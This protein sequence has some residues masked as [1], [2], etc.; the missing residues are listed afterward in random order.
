[1]ELITTVALTTILSLT[2]NLLVFYLFFRFKFSDAQKAIKQGF[3]S[4]QAAGVDVRNAKRIEKSVANDLLNAQLPGIKAL[5]GF[6]SPE[7]L[8]LIEANPE[9]VLN[10]VEKYKPLLEKYIPQLT[11]GKPG[12]KG[13]EF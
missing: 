12:E 6:L 10:L 2:L 11:G 3:T 4:M 13:Y 7:T 8:D 5:L 1:M 9:L